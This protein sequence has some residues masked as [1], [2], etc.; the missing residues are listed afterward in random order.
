MVI[1]TW[2]P[3]PMLDEY[4]VV[5]LL[6]SGAMGHVYLAHD[7]LLDRRVAVKFIAQKRPDDAARRRFLTEARALARLS[8]PHVIAAYRAGETDQHPYLV[9]ELVTGAPLSEVSLPLPEQRVIAV[10]LALARGLAAAHRRGVLHRD[11]KPANAICGEGGEI[12]LID[13]GL[14]DVAPDEPAGP[15][16]PGNAR[17]RGSDSDV[18]GTPV[19]MAPEVLRGEP[20]S[21]R[22]DVYSLG[23]LLY[24]LAT[25]T[26]PRETMPDGID[27]DAWVDA[28]G[29]W[30]HERL[31]RIAR[32]LADLITRAISA[33]P[34]ERPMSAEAMADSLAILAARP[35]QGRRIDNPYRGLGTFEAEH[36]DLFFGR[37]GET[38]AVCDRL[39]EVGLVVVAGDSGVGKSSLCRAGVVP[40]IAGGALG[41]SRQ[42]DAV[43]LIPGQRPFIGLIAALASTLSIDESSLATEATARPDSLSRTIRG[44][45]G[46]NRGLCVFLDQA[47]ELLTLSRPEE[48]RAASELLAQLAA[49]AAGCVVA[50]AVRS[51]FLTRLSTL[52]GLGE[53]VS[54]GLYLVRPLSHDG[55]RAA[56]T[57]PAAQQ[58]VMFEPAK[59]V[60]ELASSVEPSGSLPL[61]QFALAELWSEKGES[62]VIHPAMLEAIGGV[63]GALAR[64]ADAV[65]AGLSDHGKGAARRALSA[66]VT[67]EGT[68]ARQPA[69][70][71]GPPSHARDEALDA[72]V[73]GRLL[74]VRPDGAD[75]A[76]D[77]AHEALIRKWDTLQLWLADDGELR[78]RRQ[79][80][81]RSAAEW[82]RFERT[83]DLLLSGKR[84][85]DAARIGDDDLSPGARAFVSASRAKASR[86][87]RRR[88][89]LIASGPLLVAAALGGLR[90]KQARDLDALVTAHQTTARQARDRAAMLVAEAGEKRRAAYAAFDAARGT[91]LPEVLQKHDDAESTWEQATTAEHAAETELARSGQS[92]ESALALDPTRTELR[93]AIGNVT[94]ERIALADSFWRTARSDDLALRLESYDPDGARRKSRLL[95]PTLTIRT[96]PPGA[97]VGLERYDD[98]TFAMDP[99]SAATL[100]QTPLDTVPVAAGPGSYRLII[101]ILG[102]ITVRYPV[103]LK[104]GEHFEA[105]IPL[106]EDRDAPAGYVYVP[107][108]RYLT[109]SAEPD[110]LRKGFFTCG[111][112]HETRTDAYW[113]AQHELTFADWMLFLSALPEADRK[114]RMPSTQSGMWGVELTRNADVYRIELRLQGQSHVANEHEPLRLPARDRRN[115]ITWEQLPV[116]GISMEDAE[117]YFRWLDTTARV[118]GARPCTELEWERAARGA[119][120]R[121]FPHGESLGQDDANIDQTYGRKPFAFGPDEVGSHP[122]TES[123]F[124]LV[125]MTGNVSEVTL[126]AALEGE[127][128]IKGG[129]WYF[130]AMSAIV[131]NRTLSEPKTRD[132]MTG[133]RGCASGR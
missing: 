62:R 66:L 31:S 42:Y 133:L 78:A 114:A 24:E 39:R 65:I 126:S 54:R 97:T 82:N 112:L 12:K 8:H 64:H 132:Y 108:G 105:D 36:K 11:I 91:S 70:A 89:G 88:W 57:G 37:T 17:R 23:T 46:R 5:R 86:E 104:P 93:E 59:L 92:L 121:S 19:Y 56:I 80:V 123:P 122:V 51:D 45:L 34:A 44:A 29:P 7:T 116:T 76:Y 85:T 18:A 98:S 21:A 33:S 83:P 73:R 90:Y 125:D 16:E 14:A 53:E 117:A 2:T 47:E 127:I 4:R 35:I 38:Q 22:S 30:I 115:E 113:I 75:T 128:V 61:L 71:L 124:G 81:E 100:G 131:P 120:R 26:P 106:P 96:S 55:V 130:D 25:G 95:P 109:G 72:L 107:A 74:V 102:H 101:T 32:P 110:S 10:G 40:L 52:P 99:R 84:L 87:R 69:D 50:I 60:D 20:S 1:P 43:I 94:L 119:D 27:D 63:G 6:G 111:P 9:T 67:P 129:T 15:V 58:E 28:S 68:R 41:D 13:F 103:L 48:A 49:P 77:L 79:H 118:P 3:P